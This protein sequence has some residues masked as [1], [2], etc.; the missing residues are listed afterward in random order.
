MKEIL[1]SFVYDFFLGNNDLANES[2]NTLGRTKD[3]KYG[4]G[5]Y[6]RLSPIVEEVLGSSEYVFTESLGRYIYPS[7]LGRLHG[8]SNTIIN[9]FNKFIHSVNKPQQITLKAQAFMLEALINNIY[10]IYSWDDVKIA[11]SHDSWLILDQ[12]FVLVAIK[13]SPIDH[14]EAIFIVCN[15][16]LGYPSAVIDFKNKQFWIEHIG[17]PV[18]KY[19]SWI[20]HTATGILC[21]ELLKRFLPFDNINVK[22]STSRATLVVGGA[23]NPS[24][25]LWNYLGGLCLAQQLGCID[26][27]SNVAVVS[28]LLWKAEAIVADYLDLSAIDSSYAKLMKMSYTYGRHFIPIRLSD[29]GCNPIT[30]KALISHADLM[31]TGYNL[32]SQERSYDLKNKTHIET[33][34]LQSQS[35]INKLRELKGMLGDSFMCSSSSEYLECIA[36]VPDRLVRLCI[37]IRASSRR[38][39]QNQ[40]D[41]YAY[42]IKGLTCIIPNLEIVFD[43]PAEDSNDTGAS[44]RLPEN[45]VYESLQRELQSLPSSSGSL[46]VCNLIGETLEN[47]IKCYSKSDGFITIISGG[48]NK[49]TLFSNRLGLVL[50]PKC[51]ET[52]A[53]VIHI[54]NLKDSENFNYRHASSVFEPTDKFRIVHDVVAYKTQVIPPLYIL[55]N[56]KDRDSGDSSQA[57]CPDINSAFYIN[58]KDALCGAIKVVLYNLTAP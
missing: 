20:R 18:D 3:N 54:K 30:V 4:N 12:D 21:H 29:A 24:H 38:T 44:K 36:G 53:N 26:K 19:N 8:K 42:I 28:N 5:L 34:P 47:Q 25:I 55:G 15:E 46:T 17:R 10:S 6:R 51:P 22:D 56:P 48:Q 49:L 32:E 57:M 1:S 16:Y 33:C 45:L 58:P 27:A 7:R 2:L 52:L 23:V 31:A 50:G 39:F 11:S 9:E 40:I 35:R 14:K 37:T 13:F 41:C 43:G